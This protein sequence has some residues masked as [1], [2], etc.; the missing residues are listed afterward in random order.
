MNLT[1]DAGATVAIS[2]F[3]SPLAPLIYTTLE[4]SGAA[5]PIPVVLNTTVLPHFYHRDPNINTSFPVRTTA[6]CGPGGIA[7]V[8]RASDFAESGVAVTGKCI[9]HY[10]TRCDQLP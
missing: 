3:V 9:V 4:S 5:G 6:G 8:S 1:S 10:H 7:A 2:L